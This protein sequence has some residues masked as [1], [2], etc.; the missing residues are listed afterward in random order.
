[1]EGRRQR[2]G[3]LVARMCAVVVN[4][5]QYVEADMHVPLTYVV[6]NGIRHV[7]DSQRV[8]TYPL[9]HRDSSDLLFVI[10]VALLKASQLSSFLC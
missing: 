1:V 3:Y 7:F 8:L 2:V 6:L 10:L 9:D 5:I 4:K